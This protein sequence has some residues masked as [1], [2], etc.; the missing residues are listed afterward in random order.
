MQSGGSMRRVVSRCARSCSLSCCLLV[1]G[2]TALGQDRT[3]RS[4]DANMALESYSLFINQTAVAT[5][6]GSIGGQ[7]VWFIVRGVGRFVISTNPH[8]GYPFAKAGEIRGN[9]ISFQFNEVQY[10]L[11]SIVPVLSDR[12]AAEVWLMVEAIDQPKECL[13]SVSCFGA[14][15][16]FEYYMKNRR[17][18]GGKASPFWSLN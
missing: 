1:I 6:V 18:T 17:A 9:T 4:P 10:R 12:A 16:P 7:I 3:Q 14:A 8:D 13:T 2:T 5:N 11:E 15:S